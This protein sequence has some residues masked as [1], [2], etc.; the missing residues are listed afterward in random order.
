MNDP[1]LQYHILKFFRVCLKDKKTIDRSLQALLESIPVD[2]K[3]VKNTGNAVLY[4]CAKTIINLNVEDSCKEAGVE[5]V[6]R[7]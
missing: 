1:F 6:N 3:I 2:I 5:I 4:E 7:I